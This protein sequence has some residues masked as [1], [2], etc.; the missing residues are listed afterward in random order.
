MVLAGLQVVRVHQE[1][2]PVI[3]SDAQNSFCQNITAII[4]ERTIKLD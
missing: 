4:S 2:R 1:R 3:A